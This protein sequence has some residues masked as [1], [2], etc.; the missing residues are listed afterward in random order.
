MRIYITGAPGS[1]K[2]TTATRLSQLYS[3]PM[4]SLDRAVWDNSQGPKNIRLSIPVRNA[5][6]CRIAS[7]P[8]WIVEGTYGKTWLRPIFD[9]ADCVA[10]LATPTAICLFRLFKRHFVSG[11]RTAALG[12]NIV[13]FY[14]NL[15]WSLRY[16]RGP[17]HELVTLLETTGT[18]FHFCAA[19]HLPAVLD[20]LRA[21]PRSIPA[22]SL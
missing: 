1:G 22:T 14:S 7:Q 21:A 17:R 18:P 19:D 4:Y 12:D 2:T 16:D 6:I 13:H 11:L 20:K 8:S 15:S 9:R 10:I 3:L 5:N